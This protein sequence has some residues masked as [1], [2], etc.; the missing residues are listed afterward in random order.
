MLTGTP[1][2]VYAFE[3]SPLIAVHVERCAKE[4]SAGR[5][6]PP[7]VPNLP[8]TGSSKQAWDAGPAFN[9]TMM[10]EERFRC[11]EA[12]AAAALSALRADPRLQDPALLRGRLD[13]ARHTCAPAYSRYT[14]L[15]A[16]VG[17]RD[18]GSLVLYGSRGQLLR[19]GLM[20][21]SP[22]AQRDRTLTRYRHPSVP[23]VDL[24][25]WIVRSFTRDDFVVMKLDV[26][27]AEQLVVPAL[28]AHPSAGALIDVV[29]WECHPGHVRPCHELLERLRRSGVGVIYAEP[30]SWP[31]G[32][33]LCSRPQWRHP[34]LVAAAARGE[35]ELP[36]HSDACRRRPWLQQVRASDRSS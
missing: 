36:E 11:I 18:N 3:A 13:A 17:D 16:A 15:P 6:T 30:K 19:G 31:W 5:S 21:P 8:M 26:E 24:V 20:S 1:W 4:L 22:R 32:R 2:L 28:E 35:I 14:L 27:G 34:E 12:A 9:C 25:G 33:A 7:R 10:T 23:T 29:I